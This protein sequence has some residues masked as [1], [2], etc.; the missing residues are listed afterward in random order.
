[1]LPAA[2]ARNAPAQTAQNSLLQLFAQ[3]PASQRGLPC[4]K[5]QAPFSL[6][7]FSRAL[8]PSDVLYVLILNLVY[9]LSGSFMKGFGG[10]G[11][12]HCCTPVPGT[13]TGTQ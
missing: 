13:I 7:F 5:L 6:L 2:S 1:M 12:V 4:L 3:V 9:F 10:G 11:V 8:I